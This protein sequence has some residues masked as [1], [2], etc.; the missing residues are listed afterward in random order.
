MTVT[1]TEQSRRMSFGRGVMEGLRMAGVQNPGDVMN[2]A[3]LA[4]IESGL[5]SMAKKVLA[6]VPIQTPWSKEQIVSELRR[7]G[8]TVDRAVVDGCLIT[9]C[10]RG[11]VKEPA[12]GTFVRVIA[13]LI[14]QA[15]E[16]FNE[17]SINA[18]PAAAALQ[19]Q[20]PA[21]EREDSLSRLAN[22]AALLRRAA[23]EID[24]IALD[25]EARVQAAGKE[26]ETLRQLKALLTGA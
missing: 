19:P 10:E 22:V 16:E 24:G 11:V 15:T 5:N 12:R 4:R 2:A 20:P 21:P 14:T 26:G 23:D 6:A 7:A 17:V 1:P 8:A 25:V 13:R 3:K 9:L 18:R